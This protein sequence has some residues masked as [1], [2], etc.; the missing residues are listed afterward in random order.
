MT[1]YLYFLVPVLG[2]YLLQD[3]D[4]MNIGGTGYK[5]RMRFD[6]LKL[7]EKLIKLCGKEF[8]SGSDR[9]NFAVDALKGNA[10][11]DFTSNAHEH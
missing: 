5:G 9:R 3:N 8:G 6:V 10:D 2:E 4:G 1:R 7:F 11:P